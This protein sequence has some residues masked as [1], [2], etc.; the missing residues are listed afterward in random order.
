MIQND[1]IRPMNLLALY[2][3][4][5]MSGCSASSDVSKMSVTLVKTTFV[6]KGPIDEYDLQPTEVYSACGVEIT[7]KVVTFSGECPL[8][9]TGEPIDTVHY[10]YWCRLN[11]IDDNEYTRM[12]PGDELNKLS[13]D[14]TAELSIGRSFVKLLEMDEFL[15]IDV[16]ELSDKKGNTTGIWL[17]T[18]AA[19]DTY[20]LYVDWRLE[21]LFLSRVR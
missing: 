5:A 8:L 9:T 1:V 20:R 13:D 18:N 3:Y 19:R 4:L 6:S 17:V 12:Y 7:D 11:V 16:S 21:V 14:T 15:Q 2:C 10:K